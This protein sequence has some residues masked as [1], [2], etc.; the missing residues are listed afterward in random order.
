[1]DS[2]RVKRVQTTAAICITR[3]RTS[4]AKMAP[5]MDLRNVFLSSGD[6]DDKMPL[7]SSIARPTAQ[8]WFSSTLASL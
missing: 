6:S 8:W 3:E 5:I 7:A 4:V 1:M 2:A